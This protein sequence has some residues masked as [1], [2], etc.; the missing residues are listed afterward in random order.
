MDAAANGLRA[1]D[2][3]DCGFSCLQASYISESCALIVADIAHF[4]IRISLLSYPEPK[5]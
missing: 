5:N 1:P 3:Y 2:E 4:C